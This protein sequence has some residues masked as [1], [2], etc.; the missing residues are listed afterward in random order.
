[1]TLCISSLLK[2][3]GPKR[4]RCT[5]ALTR[6]FSI[7][8]GQLVLSLH[9]SMLSSNFLTVNLLATSEPPVLVDGMEH[10]VAISILQ[11]DGMLRNEEGDA[12]TRYQHA[13]FSKL[14]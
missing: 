13:D 7:P 12:H 9:A 10:E 8:S 4:K 1:M 3:N 5:P 11:D 14:K 2:L 6:T